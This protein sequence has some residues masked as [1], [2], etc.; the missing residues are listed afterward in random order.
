MSTPAGRFTPRLWL[1]FAIVTLIWGSTWLVIKYQLGE[2][3][4]SW[5]VTWRFVVAALMLFG[6]CGLTGRSLRLSPAQHRFAALVGLTQFMLNFN[7]V[8]RAEAHM[9]SGLVALIF[10]LLVI[11]NSLFA[12]ALLGQRVTVRFMAGSAMGIIGVVMMVWTDL[13]RPGEGGDEVALGV[14]LAVAGVL[15][16]SIANVMQASSMGRTLPLEGGL[17]WSMLYGAL[18]NAGVA[19]L[20]SGPPV[21]LWE[22]GYLA[23]VVYLAL[24]ASA[25]AFILYFTVVR[26]VGPGKAAWSG[27]L[28]PL[29]ALGLST[30]FEGFVWSWLAAV[31]AALALAGLIVA[32]RARST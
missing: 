26:V 29:V 21:I 8:Y 19:L 1:Y 16:A 7:F 5:S 31:G 3:P 27:V 23:G 24:A 10:A 4:P 12:W 14:A 20:L 17:A 18:M 25:V 9:A 2:V 22:A 11:P 15:S 13:A 32:L 6:F 30:L 28:I